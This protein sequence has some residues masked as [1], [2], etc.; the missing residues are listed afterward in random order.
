M[1]RVPTVQPGH[2]AKWTQVT[3]VGSGIGGGC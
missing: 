3:L 2:E 1:A